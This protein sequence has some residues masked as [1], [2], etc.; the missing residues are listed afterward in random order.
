M[1]NESRGIKNL[2]EIVE[3]HMKGDVVVRYRNTFD[4][5][6]NEKCRE[7]SN[8]TKKYKEVEKSCLAEWQ[9]IWR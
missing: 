9:I 3:E 1:Q 2:M 5:C 8:F 7:I 6:T 4:D